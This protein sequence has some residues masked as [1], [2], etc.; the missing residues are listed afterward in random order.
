MGNLRFS[1]AVSLDGYSAGPNQS[2]ENPIGE[3]GMQLHEWAF[4]ARA[5]REAHGQ[6]GG[7]EDASSAVL[8]ETTTNVGAY[9]LG[10]NMFGG[11][12][13]P[14]SEDPPWNGWWGNEPPYHAPVFVVTHHPR[15]ALPMEGGTTFH[16][17]TDGIESAL[18]QAHEAAGD[19]DIVIGGGAETAQQ[20]LRAGLVDEFQLNVVPVLLGAGTR[21]LDDLG[22]PAPAIELVRIVDA[23]GVTHLKYRCVR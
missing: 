23:P 3:G 18:A 6:A 12:P 20:Y 1:I 4:A 14:W 2:V 8:E 22:D 17:V 7:E 21:L 13:G 5:W 11:G 10:R 15:E 19:Q 9:I 16:F